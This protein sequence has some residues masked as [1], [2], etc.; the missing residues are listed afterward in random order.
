M[1]VLLEL[2]CPSCRGASFQWRHA[3]DNAKM[4]LH[5]DGDLECESGCRHFIQHWRFACSQHPGEY[6]EPPLSD[7]TYALGVAAGNSSDMSAQFL[8][9]VIVQ[10]KKRWKK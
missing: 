6:Y 2:P 4:Y 3:K 1:K 8:A 7:I 5:D 9:N 10:V